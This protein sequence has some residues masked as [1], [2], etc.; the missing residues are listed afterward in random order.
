MQA[1]SE[2][3]RQGAGEGVVHDE[4]DVK[5]AEHVAGLHMTC[6]DHTGRRFAGE[7]PRGDESPEQSICSPRRSAAAV[8]LWPLRSETPEGV[9]DERERISKIRARP[10]VRLRAVHTTGAADGAESA[11]RERE[12][13]GRKVGHMPRHYPVQSTNRQLLPDT[14]ETRY[15]CR[16][17][18]C[19]WRGRC[20]RSPRA[21]ARRR[22]R[23]R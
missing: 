18:S 6:T 20:T 11:T 1:P 8:P 15:S 19:L 16:L 2:C 9:E 23:G 21:A 10:P 22:A 13:A 14:M 12:V 7:R 5:A 3:E 4:V 17:R